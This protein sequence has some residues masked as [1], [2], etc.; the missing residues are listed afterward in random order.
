M[1]AQQSAPCL[2]LA[3]ERIRRRM[4]GL[5]RGIR[6]LSDRWNRAI[7]LVFRGPRGGRSR[8][9]SSSHHRFVPGL[10]H[11]NVLTGVVTLFLRLLLGLLD[12]ARR[13]TP[14]SRP[15]DAHDFV[16]TGEGG[17]ISAND[18]CPILT[19]SR[20]G[21]RT[22]HGLDRTWTGRPVRLIV[23]GSPGTPL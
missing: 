13:R 12:F 2:D 15:G 20:H 8:C 14:I 5:G 7:L 6:G 16:T 1:D 21:Q 19:R 10:T 4:G 22:A 3:R 17:L 18:D 9:L 23:P 11:V